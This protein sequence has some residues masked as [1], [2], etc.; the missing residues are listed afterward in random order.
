[1]SAQH[2]GN[3]CVVC[4]TLSLA[5]L[6]VSVGCSLDPVHCVSAPIGSYPQ[7]HHEICDVS[8]LLWRQ[9]FSI[10]PF[11][12][13]TATHSVGKRGDSVLDLTGQ[14][15][16]G[17]W[18]MLCLEPVTNLIG[19][20]NDGSEEERM[21][22]ALELG[23]LCFGMPFEMVRL[24]V[25]SSD[26]IIQMRRAV[27]IG[28][29]GE[30]TRALMPLMVSA[31]NDECRGVRYNIVF[32]L[33]HIGPAAMQACYRLR[34]M[35]DDNDLEV[36]LWSA[37]A[38]YAISGEIPGPLDTSI[39]LMDCIDPEIRAMAVYNIRLMKRDGYMAIPFLEKYRD[40]P[41]DRVRTQ[42]RLGLGFFRE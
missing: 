13:L 3:R 39:T 35:L 25:P 34:Q 32:A 38:L 11:D 20:L 31:L 42:V 23:E 14:W 37:R 5:P 10:E 24:Y 21:E 1:M 8:K 12:L 7:Q 33:L 40:D 22:A 9:L 36:R 15:S 28:L 17:Q 26:D 18:S 16:T 27:A 41:D 2:D 30:R 4:F 29:V 19:R 6:I